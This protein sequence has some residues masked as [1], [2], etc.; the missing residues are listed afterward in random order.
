MSRLLKNIHLV[1]IGQ[2]QVLRDPWAVLWDDEGV[3]VDTGPMAVLEHNYPRADIVDGQ[4][5]YLTPGLIDCHVHVS[6][7]GAA[8]HREDDHLSV[9]EITA[10]ALVHASETLHAGIT[11]V[12]DAGSPF[13]IGIGVR[14][15]IE[16]GWHRGPHMRVAG[17][18]FSIT[19][20][21]GDPHNGYADSV[22]FGGAAI[23]DSPDESRREAR[24]QMRQGVDVLKFMASGGVMSSGDK[25]TERGLLEEE[26]AAAVI[27]AR[28]RGKRTMAH[29]QS[30]EGIDNAIRAGVDSIEHG[31]YL[32]PWA[33]GYMAEH[34][35]YLVATLTAVQQIIDNG[36]R[37]G[38]SE[39]SVDKAKVA[40]QAHQESVLKAYRA[41]VPLALGTDA[42]TPFNIH[43]QNAQEIQHLLAVG[44][45]IWEALRAATVNAANLLDLPTGVIEPGYWAD[46]LLWDEDP[47]ERPAVLW[48]PPGPPRIF[49]RG[50]AI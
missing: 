20:G 35:V 9:P 5:K 8:D 32:S 3:I 33:I 38:I 37:A 26:M 34:Q 47:I 2:K 15:A 45:D 14:H 1:D 17:A 28:N 18:P 39:S 22:H 27:E 7:R 40:Q 6:A 49:L 29:A 25:S 16:R 48:A 13:G 42:G 10:R 50:R 46:M 19:G 44:I 43:G 21:H 41:G 11:S 4:G 24:L 36:V 23:V 12:R 31:F 30:T